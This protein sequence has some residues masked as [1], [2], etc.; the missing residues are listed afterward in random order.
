MGPWGELETR[1]RSKKPD[2]CDVD[3][4]MTS[5]QQLGGEVIKFDDGW[6]L[7]ETGGD[8]GK[9]WLNTATIEVWKWD[10]V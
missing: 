4:W 1:R 2:A 9:V 5:G 8:R 3:V 10:S 6:V 7:L